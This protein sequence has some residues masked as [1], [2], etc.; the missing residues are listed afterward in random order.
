MIIKIECGDIKQ[1]ERQFL[2]SLLESDDV[3]VSVYA[4]L[5]DDCIDF[6]AEETEKD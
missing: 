2:I 3:L 5:D 4:N 6:H 1:F